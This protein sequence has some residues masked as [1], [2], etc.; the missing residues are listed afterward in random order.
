MKALK[1]D[2]AKKVLADPLARERLRE[3]AAGEFRTQDPRVVI[4]RD[5][6][7]H[8]RRLTATVVPKA[9]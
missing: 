8:S 2:L 1:S 5:S 3:L 7:G 6:K 9:A 4:L